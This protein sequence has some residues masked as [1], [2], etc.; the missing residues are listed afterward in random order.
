MVAKTAVKARGA[1][2]SSRKGKKVGVAKGPKQ[3]RAFKDIPPVK[4][5]NQIKAA[6][7]GSKVA[8]LIDLLAS[9]KG[10]TI[11]EIEA[12][13]SKSGRPINARSWLGHSLR[14]VH[15][16]GVKSKTVDGE[17]RL[18]LDYPEGMRK[19]LPHR[20]KDEGKSE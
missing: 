20:E 8:L 16:Y 18:F 6:R 15:G 7:A 13:L 1:K 14:T 5:K 12:K 17:V 2:K 11:K 4:S 10:T 9:E 3:P 19:P